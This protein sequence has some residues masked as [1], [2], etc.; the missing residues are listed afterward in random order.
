MNAADLHA[1]D[2]QI[3]DDRIEYN[4]SKTKEKRRDRAFTSIKI[5]PEAEALLN[6]YRNLS[7]RI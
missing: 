1:C 7:K 3:I 2:Y 4:R 6:K 5:I